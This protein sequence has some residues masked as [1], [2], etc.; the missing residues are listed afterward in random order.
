MTLTA[1][2]HLRGRMSK[3]TPA[4][5]KDER[6]AWAAQAARD[7]HSMTAISAALGIGD[8][9]TRQAVINGGYH[10]QSSELILLS[11]N[12]I[13]IGGRSAMNRRLDHDTQRKLADISAKTGLPIREVQS[14]LTRHLASSLTVEEL[15]KIT[16]EVAKDGTLW[17]LLWR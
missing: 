9:P 2:D 5:L 3:H 7:G 8:N 6:N 13:R 12:G 10:R 11:R 4:A 17:D 14:C 1:P 15:V 16:K